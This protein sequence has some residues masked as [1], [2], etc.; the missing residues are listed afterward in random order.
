MVA[1]DE[2]GLQVEQVEHEISFT[3]YRLQDPS[4]RYEKLYPRK[5]APGS[6]AG[7][8]RQDEE[9]FSDSPASV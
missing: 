8:V 5:I 4:S 1:Q 2:W 7:F 6:H 9:V 3:S